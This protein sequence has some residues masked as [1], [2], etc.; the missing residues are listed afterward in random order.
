M[1]LISISHKCYDPFST[2][3]PASWISHGVVFKDEFP[4][5]VLSLD[6]SSSVC[7]SLFAHFPSKWT[8]DASLS[9]PVSIATKEFSS[10]LVSRVCTSESELWSESL[11]QKLPLLPECLS[12]AQHS[13]PIAESLLSA[14]SGELLSVYELVNNEVGDKGSPKRLPSII[15]DNVRF[16]LSGFSS[17]SSD[18]SSSVSLD[19]DFWS[20][21]F[22]VGENWVSFSWRTCK[23]ITQWVSTLYSV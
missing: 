3:I 18:S 13:L 21:D 23:K 19:D 5:P 4:P 8:V 17:S 2:H 6:M 1:T 10:P 16:K 12:L 22:A 7:K 15:S 9:A 14:D 11:S 20:G